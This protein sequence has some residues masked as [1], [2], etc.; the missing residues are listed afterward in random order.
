MLSL[1][2]TF[3]PYLSSLQFN[4][5]IVKS[6]QDNTK[7]FLQRKIARSFLKSGAATSEAISHGNRHRTEQRN[8]SWTA[9]WRNPDH[10]IL[11]VA[12]MGE[13]EL[14]NKQKG[15]R[16]E[17]QL[18]RG[19]S[20]HPVTP[21][22]LL[23]KRTSPKL[24]ECAAQYLF[25]KHRIADI[26][27]QQP[28]HMLWRWA[29]R[30]RRGDGT[31]WE[32]R[33]APTQTSPHRGVQTH[34]AER[35]RQVTGSISTA[36]GESGAGTTQGIRSATEPPD[37]SFNGAPGPMGRVCRSG[38]SQVRPVRTI[39]IYWCPQRPDRLSRKAWNR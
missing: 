8:G 12:L 29:A 4:N 30:A 11:L 38:G 26:D 16:G 22:I 10:C 27:Q 36:R 17:Q 28:A 23:V 14:K 6:F 39:K 31:G 37:P 24:D 2:T 9:S 33:A 7:R 34:R 19:R 18:R 21:C 13:G 32:L 35:R 20:D 1:A 5:F 15:Q 3:P 25:Q